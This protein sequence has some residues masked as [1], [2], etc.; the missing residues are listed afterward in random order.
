MLNAFGDAGADAAVRRNGRCSASSPAAARSPSAPSRPAGRASC[1]QRPVTSL[2]GRERVSGTVTG[3]DPEAVG[4]ALA[5]RCGAGRRRDPG[6]DPRA[7][8]P[9]ASAAARSAAA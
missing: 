9:L 2:N 1:P 6:R 4:A 3:T 7:G 5:R 8:R